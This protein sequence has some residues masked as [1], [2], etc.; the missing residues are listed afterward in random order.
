[1]GGI[2]T[3]LL[4]W[5]AGRP[6]LRSKSVDASIAWQCGAVF[7]IV[8]LCVWAVIKSEWLGLICGLAVLWLEILTI[9]RLLAIQ[10]GRGKPQ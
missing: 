5:F 2:L 1:M 10:E 6:S 4:W 3:S 7:I 9:R 8:L